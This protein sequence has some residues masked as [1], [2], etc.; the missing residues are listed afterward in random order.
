MLN[1]ENKTDIIFDLGIH[2]LILFTFWV[3]FFIMY[4]S[5]ILTNSMKEELGHII[6]SA[7]PKGLEESRKL[8]NNQTDLLL[9]MI[10]LDNFKNTYNKESQVNKFNNDWLFTVMIIMNIV[11]FFV[12][13]LSY[14]ILSRACSYEIDL[15]DILKINAITF[16][17]IGA[18]EFVFFENVALKFVPTKPSLM[19][20]SIFEDIRNYF[21]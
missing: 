5:K 10:P 3:V 12:I 9:K 18:I 11:F 4:V 17:F 13:T 1:G 6:T 14:V 21:K 2:G 20:N 19:T 8:T 7:V 15:L 16:V